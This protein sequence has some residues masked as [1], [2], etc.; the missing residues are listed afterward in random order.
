LEDTI[1]AIVD[2]PV[3]VH[4]AG[5]TDTG[6]HA[7]AMVAHFETNSL[8]PPHRWAKV[9]N[10]R[11]PGDILVRASVVVPATWHARFSALWRRY[12]YTLYTDAYPNLFA[13]QTTWHYYQAP[14]QVELIQAALHPLLG[15]QHLTAF[16]R[17]NSGRAHSWVEIQ[18][19]LCQRRGAFVDIEVQASG[20][21]YGM[22]R[23]LVGLLV[24]VG[25]GDCSPQA[26]TALW[27]GEHR[28]QVKYA[29]PAKGLC[30]LAVGYPE[31]PFPSEAWQT[32]LPWLSLTESSPT[33]SIA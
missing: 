26:F 18:D 19:V 23:L 33:L 5:R 28:D 20:F 14:L 17:A 31:C 16:H 30:L 21:L 4:G 29:A 13:Q 15:R 11:L 2:H 32:T 6:V 27:Q 8:I 25:S 12:R 1:A 10:S 9:L 22:M 24:Q 3:I 7:S